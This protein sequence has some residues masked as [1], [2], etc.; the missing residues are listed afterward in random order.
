MS[1]LI[2]SGAVSKSG[3]IRTR[4]TRKGKKEIAHDVGF[5]SNGHEELD[6]RHLDTT[7]QHGK[8]GGLRC[9]IYPFVQ[10]IDDNDGWNIHRIERV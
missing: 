10:P 6:L 9:A 3:K 1:L 2:S 7:T 8:D 4:P 5:Q